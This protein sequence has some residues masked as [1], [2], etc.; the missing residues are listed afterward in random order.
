VELHQLRYFLAI[1][2]AGS[3]TAAAEA[4]HVSQPSLSIQVAKLE[5]ELGGVLVER[6]RQ[7]AR[8]TA[9]GHLFLPRA[10]EILRQIEGVR[11]DLDDLDGLHRG[12]VILGCLPTT[13]A[14]LL[15]PL[16]REFR[17][18][19]PDLQVHLTEESSPQLA[20]GLVSGAMDLALL[21][22]AGLG[23]G[24][25]STA[26]FSEP[27]LVAVPPEHPLAGRGAIAV[28]ALAN[29][30]LILMKPGHGFRQIVLDYLQSRGLVPRIV[31]ESSG[32]ETVQALV[33]AG[34]GVSLVPRMVRKSPG[35]AYLDLLPPTPTRT[36]FLAGRVGSPG[37]P[38]SQ[39]LEALIR[40]WFSSGSFGGRL[41]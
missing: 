38:A 37:S 24:L 17:R 27:L 25:R 31:Y 33:E 5:D 1:V 3:F 6:H 19:H 15:P 23:P 14:Y 36:L 4:C 34:M 30:P 10:V 35:P 16:L 7:G 40:G 28:E 21:D 26:L 11:R 41:G 8:L 13:G 18:A 29:E 39:A 32:I 20:E 12:E 2:E 22:E 9:R